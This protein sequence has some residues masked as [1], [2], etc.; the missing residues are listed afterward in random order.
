[1]KRKPRSELNAE[2]QKE[3]VAWIDQN[4]ATFPEP[5]RI[6]LEFHHQYLAADGNACKSFDSTYRELANWLTSSFRG[7][8]RLP[9]HEVENFAL[10]ERA[11]AGCELNI[12]NRSEE[13]IRSRLVSKVD[14]LKW[15][16]ACRQVL[17]RLGDDYFQEFP[18]HPPTSGQNSVSS[19]DQAL[20]FIVQSSWFKSMPD[21]AR[22]WTDDRL[23]EQLCNAEKASSQAIKDETWRAEFP[24]KEIL[25]SIRDW[26]YTVH[27]AGKGNERASKKPRSRVNP[28]RANPGR[29]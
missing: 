11:L 14:G 29:Y 5:V 2:Q 9:V 12:G 19:L 28:A 13:E 15:W 16:W 18:N 24:G 22:N 4:R 6:F 27:G 17:S 10:D 1:V 26:L 8:F 21:R 3:I 20:S 7:P 23:K 25:R